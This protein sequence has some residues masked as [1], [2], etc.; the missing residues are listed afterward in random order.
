MRTAHSLVASAALVC[1]VACSAAEGASEGHSSASASGATTMSGPTASPVGTSPSAAAT[2]ATPSGAQLPVLQGYRLARSVRAPGDGP[3]VYTDGTLWAVDRKDAGFDAQGRMNGDLWLVD[4]ATARISGHV[5]HAR[6]GFPTAG[7]GALWLVNA[8]YGE[9]VTRVGLRNHRVVSF[10][11]SRTQ[12]PVPEAVVVAAGSVW[13]GNNHD[14][15]A[16]KVDPRNL[17][18]VTRVHIS[19]GG[20]RGHATTD[21]RYVWMPS[22]DGHFVARIDTRSDRVVSTFVVPVVDHPTRPATNPDELS[23]PEWLE[24]VDGRLWVATWDHVYV[25]DISRV[26]AER[27]VADVRADGVATSLGVGRDAVW[28]ATGEP[29]ALIRIDR[30]RFEVTGAMPLDSGPMMF[31]SASTAVPVGRAVWIRV[32]G[33]LLEL[34]PTGSAA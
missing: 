18:V 17:D 6:G 9:T 5:P 21:G 25:V 3:L 30:A 11:T 26:G 20:V 19:S 12:D 27:I 10:R 24:I 4:P 29:S 22:G 2:G 16:V 31:G 1:L 14:G 34:V 23:Q 33:R 32:K 7:L 28:A 13:V 8:E 15:D